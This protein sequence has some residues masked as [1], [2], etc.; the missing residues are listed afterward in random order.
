M[1]KTAK[2]LIMC[3]GMVCLAAFLAG[4]VI[5][6]FFFSVPIPVFA[7]GI[8]FGYAVTC[9][10][11]V[12]LERNL[13]RSADLTSNKARVYALLG[14]FF[15]YILTF[16]ALALAVFMPFLDMWGAFIGVLSLQPA[17]YMVRLFIKDEDV[18]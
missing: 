17:G 13:N 14:F 15:R 7:A 1:S 18:I 16:G 5:I 12:S 2:K 4:S 11:V 10:R 9:F 6:L 3:A 8:L